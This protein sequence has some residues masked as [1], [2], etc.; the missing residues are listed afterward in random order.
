MMKKYLIASLLIILAFFVGKWTTPEKVLEKVKTVETTKWRTNTRVI[1]LPDGTI[2]E[3]DI[4]E[5]IR[6]QIEDKHIVFDTKK[7]LFSISATPQARP[8]YM[9][10]VSKKFLGDLYLGAYG[11]TDGEYGL[12]LT[13]RF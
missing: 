9:L 4:R 12:S 13:Y 10:G 8:I 7:Y 1:T 5:E 3:E 11:R 6:Q 2:I